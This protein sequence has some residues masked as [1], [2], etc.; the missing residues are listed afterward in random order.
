MSCDDANIVREMATYEVRIYQSEQRTITVEGS[1]LQ[2]ARR[3]EHNAIP[4][5]SCRTLS[6]A[7]IRNADWWARTSLALDQ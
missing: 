6:L 7:E 5:G 1:S 4:E 3:N 2:K